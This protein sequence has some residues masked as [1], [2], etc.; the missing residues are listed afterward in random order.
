MNGE[1][2]NLKPRLT[3]WFSPHIKP[4]KQEKEVSK[5]KEG[6]KFMCYFTIKHTKPIIREI[7]IRKM[8]FRCRK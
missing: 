8:M 1:K 2:F 6:N 3:I 5:L 7:I 4:S